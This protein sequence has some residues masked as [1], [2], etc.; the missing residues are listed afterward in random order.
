MPE[1]LP[2]PLPPEPPEIHAGYAP[3]PAASWPP[4][5]PALAYSLPTTVTGPT[6]PRLITAI[7][8]TS[9]V[10]AFLGAAGAILTAVAAFLFYA[11]A[12]AVSASALAAQIS[13]VSMTP[14]PTAPVRPPPEVGP[15]GLSGPQRRGVVDAFYAVRP[16]R[17]P[18]ME[19]LDAILARHGLTILLTPADR[20]AG[21]DPAPQRVRG[22]VENHGQLFSTNPAS[23]PDFFRLA[24]GRLELYDDRAVFYPADGST[25]LRNAYGRA[26][27]RR[28]LTAAEAAGVV[29]RAKGSA[30]R[31]VLNDAQA[32]A[33]AAALTKGDQ[34]W[35]PTAGTTAE[36][37]AGLSEPQSVTPAA[38]G[39]VTLRFADGELHLGPQ[40]EVL[41]TSP[42][43]APPPKPSTAAF[44]VIMAAALAA[45]ALAIVLFAAGVLL[46]RGLPSGRRLHLT[47]AWLKI[48]V[49]A[50]AAVTFW[51]MASSYYEAMIQYNQ[52][53][54]PASAPRPPRLMAE[55][56][57][58]VAAA[59]P[60]LVYPLVVLVLMR[61]RTVREY[62]HP[63][64]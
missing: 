63:T 9:L 61:G 6:R 14:A 16:I 32:R 48:P 5:A 20:E 23:A 8:T 54:A 7:G 60:A 2:P 39:A 43:P 24:T 4:A 64:E 35:V 59:L 27:T 44:L 31:G 37:P 36:R 42:G 13:A 56:W 30:P 52:T 3:P 49:T 33:L 40:G 45:F 55:P 12:Q 46:L 25:A 21:V 10:F 17:P 34:K 28:A 22:L 50:A 38:G 26:P 29:E 57:L 47:W 11:R 19:Q 51:W 15:N 1:P 41:A 18:R 53:V 62:F 58:P